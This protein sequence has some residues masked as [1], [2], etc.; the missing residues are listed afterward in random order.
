M[1]ESL[2]LSDNI[3]HRTMNDHTVI[4]NTQSGKHFSLNKTAS[5][6]FEHVIS[7]KNN[8]DITKELMGQFEVAEKTLTTDVDELIMELTSKEILQRK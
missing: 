6:I 4:L 7:G 8:Q 3:I 2:V 5:R 1:T